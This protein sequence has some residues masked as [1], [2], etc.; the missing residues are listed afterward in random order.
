MMADRGIGAMTV[1][2]VNGKARY[3]LIPES[4]YLHNSV[5]DPT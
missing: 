3:T 2:I 1:A 5:I 4:E